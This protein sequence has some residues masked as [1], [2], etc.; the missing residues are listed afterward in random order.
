MRGKT[1]FIEISSCGFVEAIV[2]S[3]D[4]KV[5]YEA[6][7]DFDGDLS[8]YGITKGVFINSVAKEVYAPV[9]MWIEA[10]DL[11]L[12]RLKDNGAALSKVRGIS[13]AGQQHG[14]VFWSERGMEILSLL[15]SSQPLVE[16]L[17]PEAF[18]HPWSPNWQDGSTQ[19]ECDDFDVA[20]GTE[21][22]LAYIT[23]S[24][25]HHVSA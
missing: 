7:V 9:A 19:M 13:G 5:R 18:S 21:D 6:K 3:S 15:N 23:G 20:F 22:K 1:K 25:A 16:Q 2:I 24:K 12:K 14:S 11:V 4:L 17:S 10:L 8:S